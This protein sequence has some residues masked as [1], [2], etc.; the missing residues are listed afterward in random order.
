MHV[1]KTMVY[2]VAEGVE[3]GGG[4]GGGLLGNAVEEECAVREFVSFWSQLCNVSET[5]P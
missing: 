1:I 2:A 5:L 4:G 3:G